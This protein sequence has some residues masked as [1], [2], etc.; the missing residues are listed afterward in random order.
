M[1][2]GRPSD[3]TPKLL[4]AAWDYVENCPDVIPS[5]EGLCEAISI[6]RSTAY[7]W[8]KD[9]DKEFSYILEALMTKQGK[10]LLNN[11]LDGTFNSTISKLIL[12]KHGYSDKQE[13]EH[14][15]NPDKP[16]VSRI[17]QVIVDPTS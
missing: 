2:A 3:Y 7:A 5:I 16:L 4:K 9:E 15:G 6:A 11:G 8:A 13:L 12:T 1:P 14:S 10:T 17:E